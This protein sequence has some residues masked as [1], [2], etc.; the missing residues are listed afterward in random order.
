MAAVSH[1]GPV[2]PDIA[3]DPEAYVRASEARVAGIRPGAEKQ[4]VW[5]HADRRRTPLAVVYIHGFSAS[6]GEIRPVPDRVAADFSAN[7]FFTRLAG[8]GIDGAALGT[9]TLAQ[10]LGDVAEAITIGQALG[11]KIILMGI[12]TGAALATWALS[13]PQ[14]A[15]PVA[16]TVLVSPNFGLK[17]AGGFLLEAPFAR[18]IVHLALGRTRNVEPAT[19]LQRRIWTGI[20]PTDALLPMAAAIGLARRVRVEAIQ[21]PALL[22]YCP[23]DQIVDPAKTR[24][25]ADRWGGPHL[26]IAV[27]HT[28]DPNGHVLAGDAYAPANNET[29]VTQICGWLRQT[30]RPHS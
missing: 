16:A 10:W 12:S 23:R 11:E 9:A 6:A 1:P 27:A 14:L 8:H 20:Y 3:G 24:T 18:Q 2:A 7:L 13:Q 19:A 22:I 30:L 5:A 15:G 25:V 17:A 21:T 28:D 26:L 29:L 4:I